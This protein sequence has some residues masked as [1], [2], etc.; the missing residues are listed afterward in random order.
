MEWCY[1]SWTL[2]LLLDKLWDQSCVVGSGRARWTSWR[3]N[4]F[5]LLYQLPFCPKGRP[6]HCRDFNKVSLFRTPRVTKPLVGQSRRSLFPKRSTRV[7][8]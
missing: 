2:L 3:W 1:Y 6:G 4:Y 7:N 8:L 5:P